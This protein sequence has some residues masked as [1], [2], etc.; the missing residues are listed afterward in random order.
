MGTPQRRASRRVL[1]IVTDSAQLFHLPEGLKALQKVAKEYL[2]WWF[3]G[4]LTMQDTL[5]YR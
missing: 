2:C 3:S 4:V 1:V 5:A